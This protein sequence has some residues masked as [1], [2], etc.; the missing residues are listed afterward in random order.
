MILKTD[1]IKSIGKIIIQICTF[2]ISIGHKLT[3]LNFGI[4]GSE[5]LPIIWS[6][7]VDD[8]AP[9][10]GLRLNHMI[11]SVGVSNV[12]HYSTSSGALSSAEGL[13]QISHVFVKKFS[14]IFWHL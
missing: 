12:Y 3:V 5:N 11:A 8:R 7:S 14:T 2:K 6:P 13:F 10:V 9:G 4:F 1:P